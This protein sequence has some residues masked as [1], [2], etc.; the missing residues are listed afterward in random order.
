[1]SYAHEDEQRIRPL[2]NA[3]EQRGLEVFWNRK[4]TPGQNWHDVITQE[5]AN[6]Q[7]VIVVWSEQSVTRSF[8]IEEA[9]EGKERGVLVPVLLDSGVQLPLGFRN[10]QVAEITQMREGSTAAELGGVLQV[11]DS[12]I[13]S[14]SAKAVFSEPRKPSRVRRVEIG[15]VAFPKE[16]PEAH[17]FY[18][19]ESFRPR[20]IFVPVKFD[21]PFVGQPKIVVSLRK[22]DLGDARSNIH[23]ISVSAQDVDPSGFDLYFQTWAESQIYDAVA[24]WTA[25]GE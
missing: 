3:L 15:E 11:V 21:P 13:R 1:M 16:H 7:C 8:V 9:T 22:I 19:A 17:Q 24:C 12:V 5:L 6:A 18:D 14:S 4:I 10:I 2:V 25:I 23:R 20:E